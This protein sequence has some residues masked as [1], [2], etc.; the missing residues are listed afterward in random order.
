VLIRALTNEL[1]F[2]AEITQSRNSLNLLKFSDLWEIALDVHR[3]NNVCVHR[4]NMVRFT[5][6]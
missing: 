6:A 2:D 3:V 5:Q 4:M 1:K